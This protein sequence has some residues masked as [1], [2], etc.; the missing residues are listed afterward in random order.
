MCCTSPN[1]LKRS[2]RL[3]RAVLPQPTG[4]K[5]SWTGEWFRGDYDSG[6][7]AEG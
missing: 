4:A 5:A 3:A 6:A 7:V 1:H 2:G